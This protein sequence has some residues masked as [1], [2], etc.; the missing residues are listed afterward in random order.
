MKRVQRL[1][2][3]SVLA[4]ALGFSMLP[5]SAMACAAEPYIGSVCYMVTSYCPEGYLRANGQLVP[6]NQ[7][8]ALYA[9]VGY[10]WG[11]SQAQ[12]TF[13]LPD[14]R[15]RVVAGTGQGPGLS[16]VVLGQ[17]YG[18]EN[19]ALATNNVAPHLHPATL[20]P[21]TGTA[22][23]A[24]PVV[25]GAATTNVPGNTVS[26]AGTSPSFDL[27]PV[28]GVDSPAKIYS[29]AATNATL[30]PFVVPFSLG[31]P[32]GV[33]IGA[34]TG[35]TPFSIRNPSVGLTACIAT[36]GIFPMNPN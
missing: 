14:L 19:V 9:L 12:G 15:S 16:N 33:T 8:Q 31:T 28:G 26:L 7:Y 1:L 24:I 22:S 35:G 27:S 17:T 32:S 5:T 6:T 29:N 3:K 36:S 11:G 30:K 2:V 13:G 25:T 10:T 18:A 21:L 23:V 34:N 20:S 4:S